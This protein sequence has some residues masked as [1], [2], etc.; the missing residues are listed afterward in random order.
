MSS[1]PVSADEAPSRIRSL[2]SHSVL[3]VVGLTP[4]TRRTAGD[5]RL[6]VGLIDGP[7]AINHPDLA[8][9]H[10]RLAG[11]KLSGSCT[12]AKSTACLHGTFVAGIL[13]AA[14]ESQTPGICPGCTL[15]VR[16]IFDESAPA[17]RRMPTTTPEE[18]AQ[19]LVEI[20]AAG[21]RI[22]NLSA[23]LERPHPGGARRLEEAMNYAAQRGVLIVAAAGN[24]GLVGSSAI[25]RHAWVIPVAACDAQGSPLPGSNLGRSI[26]RLGLRAPGEKITSLGAPGEPLAL[27]GTSVAAPL[28][29]GTAALL[30]SIFP[31]AN[32]LDLKLALTRS[33]S[34]RRTTVVPPLLN[35]WNAYAM[36][37]RTH[38]QGGR[39]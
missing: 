16:P 25:T 36:L 30:W 37:A 35:A 5:P 29:T 13:C 12:T 27:G 28:V 20:I 3:D 2:N 4:L 34:E 21:A 7:V 15:L 26:A 14:K 18:L 22:I 38:V 39:A 23:A 24:Q 8:R 33:G 17:T 31:T 9:A 11:T 19:A 10:I 6:T 32:A 1:M